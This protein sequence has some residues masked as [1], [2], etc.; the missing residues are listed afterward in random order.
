MYFKRPEYDEN[1][2]KAMSLKKNCADGWQAVDSTPQEESDGA[3]QMGPASIKLVKANKDA[4]CDY[5]ASK[6][7]GNK[8]MFGCFDHEFVISEVNSNVHLWVKNGKSYSPGFGKFLFPIFHLT[9]PPFNKL[10]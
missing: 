2:C 4:A 10:V 8:K 9:N 6:N 3:Y 7:I 1:V 5:W